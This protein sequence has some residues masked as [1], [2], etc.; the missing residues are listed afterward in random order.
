[1]AAQR[2]SSPRVADRIRFRLYMDREVDGVIR[3]IL[4]TPDGVRYRVEY[5]SNLATITPD[6][7]VQPEKPASPDNLE[8]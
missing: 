4:K 6:A 8:L 5:G 3:A 1:M 2:T 7:I